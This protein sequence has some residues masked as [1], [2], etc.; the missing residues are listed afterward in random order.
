[1]SVSNA[2]VSVFLIALLV[3]PKPEK[4]LMYIFARFALSSLPRGTVAGVLVATIVLFRMQGCEEELEIRAGGIW[5]RRKSFAAPV[6]SVGT[7]AT[8]PLTFTY[9][10]HRDAA[11]GGTGRFRKNPKIRFILL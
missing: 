8:L 10:P 1:M 5:T 11:H 4:I 6:L 9:V 3:Q 7:E 2:P